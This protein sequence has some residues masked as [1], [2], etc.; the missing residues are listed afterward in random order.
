MNPTENRKYR[1]VA[2]RIAPEISTLVHYTK[3]LLIVDDYT[4]DKWYYIG[5]NIHPYCGTTICGLHSRSGKS[6]E[7]SVDCLPCVM[8]NP[9]GEDLE[10][11]ETIEQE[12]VKELVN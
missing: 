8:A 2:V 4:G 6:T 11:G 9:Y 7:D 12:K 3:L 5:C 1:I 10:F